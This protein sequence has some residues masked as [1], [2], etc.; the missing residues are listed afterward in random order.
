MIN[1]I[2]ATRAEADPVIAALKLKRISTNFDLYQHD[3]IQLIISGMGKCNVATACGWLANR[4]FN[5]EAAG[6]T[7]VAWLNFGI[8]GHATHELGS[9]YIAH[10]ITDLATGELW[11]PHQFSNNLP[12]SELTTVD[13]PL[14][15]YLPDQL[16]DMEAS[17]FIKATRIFSDAE[18]VQCIKVV[19]DNRTNPLSAVNAKF[20]NSLITNSVEM[21][22]QQAEQL[23]TLSN[24]IPQPETRL[25]NLLHSRWH[26]SAS[27]TTQLRRLLQRY[28]ALLD[29][30]EN[31]PEPLQQKTSSKDVLNWLKGQVDRADISL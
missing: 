1:L 20:A 16:H 29:S 10:K 25:F 18:L 11:Y 24:T 3:H 5:E 8:A 14:L 4:T 27:Q 15:D 7:S 22:I 2:A 31:I 12:S 28:A 23:E 21:I 9:A 30:A 17:S 6:A 26:F 13:T 19:S